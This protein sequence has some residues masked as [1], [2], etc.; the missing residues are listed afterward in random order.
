M[1]HG[2]V[3]GS[4]ILQPLIE[5]GIIPL[6]LLVKRYLALD[7]Y[8]IHARRLINMQPAHGW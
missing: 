6:Y 8:I 2:N 3:Y 5:E 4:C 7:T 1:N